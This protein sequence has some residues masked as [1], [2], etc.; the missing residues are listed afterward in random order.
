MLA[1]RFEGKIEVNLQ[2]DAFLNSINPL[3]A[4]PG[5]TT[6]TKIVYEVVRPSVCILH[7]GKNTFNVGPVIAGSTFVEYITITNNCEVSVP[8]R[9]SLSDVSRLQYICSFFVFVEIL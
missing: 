9:I 8:L 5:A 4:T 6:T 3:N 1:P 7:R 2:I